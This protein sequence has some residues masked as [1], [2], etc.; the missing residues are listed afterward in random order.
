MSGTLSNSCRG[1]TSAIERLD[2]KK[3]KTRPRYIVELPGAGEKVRRS[4]G[5]DADVNACSGNYLIHGRLANLCHS[6][7]GGCFRGPSNDMPMQ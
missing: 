4:N 2:L 6:L 7:S 3:Y 5:D 1:S